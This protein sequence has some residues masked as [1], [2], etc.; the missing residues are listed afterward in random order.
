M[1]C[2]F[3]FFVIIIIVVVVYSM[4]LS[5]PCIIILPSGCQRLALVVKSLVGIDLFAY[6][7]CSG[8][9]FDFSFYF[10]LTHQIAFSPLACPAVPLL[11]RSG[12][13]IFG[14]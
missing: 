9:F 10:F 8:I 6:L 2:Y 3:P 14:Q 12:Y 11:S 13:V 7:W 4:V 5:L 1:S